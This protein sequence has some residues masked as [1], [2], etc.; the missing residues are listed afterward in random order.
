VTTRGYAET[1]LEQARRTV[2]EFFDAAIVGAKFSPDRAQKLFLDSSL[3]SM[4]EQGHP[5][6]LAGLSG[7]ECLEAALGKKVRWGKRS[8]ELSPAYWAGSMLALAQWEL[9]RPFAE[10]L[11]KVP[12]TGFLDLYNPYH[13]APEEK[14]ISLIRQSFPFESSLKRI[15][16]SRNLSQR[17][18]SLLSG[19]KLRSIQCY[20]QGDIDIR[21]AQ[22]D[23]L[24]ALAQ[25][26]Q[27]SIEELLG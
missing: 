5:R 24:L 20:E 6:Y 3:P 19:V 8:E 2:G 18:L 12:F 15:R 10:I 25:T 22:G 11:F 14:V 26:L 23:A 27:C 1:Y 16:L 4:L 13:E 21:H 17:D 9:H 7:I